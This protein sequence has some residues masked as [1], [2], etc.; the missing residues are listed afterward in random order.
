MFEQVDLMRV[1]VPSLKEYPTQPRRS[2]EQTA[3]DKAELGAEAQ[4]IY[5]KALAGASFEKLEERAYKL[6]G[7]EEDTPAVHLGNLTRYSIPMEYRETIFALKVGEISA[8]TP[9]S[10][11]WSIFKVVSKGKMPLSEAKP[12]VQQIKADA[13]VEA[14]KNSTKLNFNQAYFGTPEP[15]TNPPSM[16]R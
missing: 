12:Q 4:K 16:R 11:G 3:A 2:K 15:T 5:K 7:N 13:A 9:E 1:F 14:I 10:N 8:L 6:A